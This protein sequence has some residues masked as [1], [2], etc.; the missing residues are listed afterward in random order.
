[1]QNTLKNVA[2]FAFQNANLKAHT[3]NGWCTNGSALRQEGE[4]STWVNNSQEVC[5]DG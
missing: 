4:V 2:E 5:T 1:M 3:M